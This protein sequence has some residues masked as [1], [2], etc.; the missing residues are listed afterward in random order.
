MTTKSYRIAAGLAHVL[1]LTTCA[2]EDSVAPPAPNVD[3]VATPTSLTSQMVTGSAEFGSTVNITGGAA[4]AEGVADVFTA[5][6]SIEVT[7][8][9]DSENMLSLTATDGAG[10]IS[11]ATT[12]AIVHEAAQPEGLVLTVDNPVPF[13]AIGSN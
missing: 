7:L 10:N 4:D 8:T 13:V 3:A 5:R 2:E 1:A 9:A 6:F 12:V 11:E